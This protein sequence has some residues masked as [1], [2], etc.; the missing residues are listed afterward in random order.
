MYMIKNVRATGIQ[1]QTKQ[2]HQVNP[3]SLWGELGFLFHTMNMVSSQGSE[4]SKIVSANNF[5]LSLRQIPEALA[6]GLIESNQ[7]DHQMDP[8]ITMQVFIKFLF[9]HLQRE[10]DNEIKYD[11]VAPIVKGKSNENLGTLLASGDGSGKSSSKLDSNSKPPHNTIDDIF[12]FTTTVQTTFLQSNVV[13]KGVALRSTSLELVYPSTAPAPRNSKNAQ[14]KHHHLTSFSAIVISSFVK[15]TYMRG[16]CDTS[17]AYEPFRQS[18][19]ISSIAQVRS[20]HHACT[21]ILINVCTYAFM[22]LCIHVFMYL[23]IHV[24]MYLCLSFVFRDYF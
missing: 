6:L 2:Y 7:T 12:G 15:E 20:L 1:A 14:K 22:Y 9:S 8:Q 13:E 19:T 4:T 18:R 17:K 11:P 5:Q 3:F 23:C 24:F 16:W 21:S 10:T